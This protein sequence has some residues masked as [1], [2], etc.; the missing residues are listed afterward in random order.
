MKTHELL[1]EL[2]RLK[3]VKGVYDAVLQA[4]TGEV[5]ERSW[6]RRT[7]EKGEEVQRLHPKLNLND[8]RKK[9]EG[10]V[11]AIRKLEG[12]IRDANHRTGAA[13]LLKRAAEIDTDLKERTARLTSAVHYFKSDGRP[14][15][16]P[17]EIVREMMTLND[18]RAKLRKELQKLNFAG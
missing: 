4:A 7:R 11:A 15:D 16:D 6:G 17:M 9:R 12:Q 5:A 2:Q 10:V 18:E 8:I 13:P 14:K 3:A 1:V